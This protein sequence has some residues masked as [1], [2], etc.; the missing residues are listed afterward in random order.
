MKRITTLIFVSLMA[1][2]LFASGKRE[3]KPYELGIGGDLTF[4][5]ES[6][7]NAIANYDSFGFHFMSSGM[8][9]EHWGILTNIG[10]YFPYNIYGSIAGE[11]YTINPSSYKLLMGM[12]T[13]ISA[14]YYLIDTGSI[15]CGVGPAADLLMLVAQK[16]SN[17]V[18]GY[19]GGVGAVLDARFSCTKNVFLNAGVFA[20][21]NF[22]HVSTVISGTTSSSSSG[23]TSC[24]VCK[25]YLGI[26]FMINPNNSASRL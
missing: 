4:L 2:G 26:G 11:K 9:N 16:P 20:F 1:F 21:Y 25:P 3:L 24:F 8:M 17:L 7:Q 10:L 22:I 13:I 14:P 6:N 5:S 18:L 12:Q 15:K 23:L 19:Y